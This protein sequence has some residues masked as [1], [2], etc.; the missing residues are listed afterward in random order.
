ME[1]VVIPGFLGGGGT[2]HHPSHSVEIEQ[3]DERDTP[4]HPLSSIVFEVPRLLLRYGRKTR[5]TMK[6]TWTT[7]GRTQPAC[8]VLR[9]ESALA[10]S[11]IN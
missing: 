10:I 4:H 11:M 2:R 8:F 1:S 5:T 6:S 7:T 3:V 9:S